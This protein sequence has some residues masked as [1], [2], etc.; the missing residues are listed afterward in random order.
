M[1]RARLFLKLAM[2]PATLVAQGA[3]VTDLD[4]PLL[5]AEDR[6]GRVLTADKRLLRAVKNNVRWKDRVIA[7][8]DWPG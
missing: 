8:A 3:L 4:W 5:L 1:A 6:H 2:A 7:L